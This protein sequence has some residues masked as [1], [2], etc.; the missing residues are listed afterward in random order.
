MFDA[1][2]TNYDGLNR[3]ISFG[4][5]IKWRK[6]VLAIVKKK[7]PTTILDIATGTGDLALLMSEIEATKIIGLDISAGML[8]VR[9]K[10]IAQKNLSK[11]IYF[12]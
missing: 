7:N 11:K 8:D 10:K 3:V 1:I 6:K 5:D 9:R 2:S 12:L 4:T